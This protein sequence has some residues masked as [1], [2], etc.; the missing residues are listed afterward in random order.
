MSRPRRI[1]ILSPNAHMDQ[2]QADKRDIR[3]KAEQ[4]FT[5]TLVLG[6]AIAASY[7]SAGGHG[8][9]G[10]LIYL[11]AAA[12]TGLARLAA[13]GHHCTIGDRRAVPGQ[14]PCF[15]TWR[16]RATT[17][18]RVRRHSVHRCATVAALVT[19]LRDCV[20]VLILG[21]T[22]FACAQVWA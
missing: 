8:T 20:R 2:Q 7:S 1:V 12:L 9:P 11:A 6:A 3:A 21:F 10:K 4:V 19:V 16:T 17:S 18:R 5:T 14:P 15:A 22:T 13:G